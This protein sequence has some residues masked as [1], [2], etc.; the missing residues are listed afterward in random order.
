MLEK[1][2]ESPLDCKEIKLV[3]PKGNKSQIFIGRSVAEGEAPILWPPNA[4]SQLIRKEPDAEKDGRQEQKQTTD[5]EMRKWN[6]QHNGYE[7][8][9]APADGERQGSLVCCSP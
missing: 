5:D 6:H 1:T 2:L 4:K 8:E 9:Q 3:N 7:F